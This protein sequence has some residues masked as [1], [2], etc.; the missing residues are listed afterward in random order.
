MKR[1][2][3]ILVLAFTPFFACSQDWTLINPAYQYNY[4][5]ADS[6]F[7][8]NVIVVDSTLV[9]GSETTYFLNRVGPG[10]ETIYDYPETILINLPQFLQ[11]KC[12]LT[13]ENWNFKDPGNIVF[14]RSPITGN[15][16]TLDSLQSIEATLDS[17]YLTE[18]LNTEDSVRR[19]L[20]SAGD[21]I[22]WSRLFGILQFPKDYGGSTYYRLTGIDGLGVGEHYPTKKDFYPYQPGDKLEFSS[23]AYYPEESDFFQFSVLITD[24]QETDSTITFTFSN[25]DSEIDS[26]TYHLNK[27]LTH[28]IQDGFPNQLVPSLFSQADGFFGKYCWTVASCYGPD[29]LQELYYFYPQDVDVGQLAHAFSYDNKLFKTSI[30]Y[31]PYSPNFINQSFQQIPGS[32]STYAKL[33]NYQ[34]LLPY[35][36]YLYPIGDIHLHQEFFEGQGDLYLTRYISDGDTLFEAP[37]GVVP[38]GLAEIDRPKHLQVYPNPATD[39][40]QIQLPDNSPAHLQL[41][42]ISGKVIQKIYLNGE[43]SLSV[44]GLKPGFYLIKIRQGSNYFV[45]RFIKVRY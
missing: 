13:P 1:C 25:S 18:N 21:T 33:A 42:D 14:P 17:V 29:Q 43:N 40:V 22:L 27:N 6:T 12:K 35:I 4:R 20:T 30:P 23:S 31:L 3:F 2:I 11:R 32:D 41:L 26:V 37:E 8:T 38:D 28:E 39:R 24:R 34:S 36:E 5:L 45:A 16:W 10:V 19:I 7:I 44:S 9:E 15:S